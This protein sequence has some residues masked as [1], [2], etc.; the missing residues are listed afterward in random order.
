MPIVI[1]DVAYYEKTNPDHVERDARAVSGTTYNDLDNDAGNPGGITRDQIS[2]ADIRTL[3]E[4][5]VGTEVFIEGEPRENLD[6]A[7]ETGGSRI[8]WRGT[9]VGTLA[10]GGSA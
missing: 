6:D 9:V 10:P 5:A 4:F 7:D 8:W 3:G 1:F 2:E